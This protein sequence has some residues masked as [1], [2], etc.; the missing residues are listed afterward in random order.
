MSSVTLETL[1][2]AVA[3]STRTCQT[4]R[5]LL[6][7]LAQGWED[8][9]DTVEGLDRDT[10]GL[11]SALQAL[12][13][14]LTKVQELTEWSESSKDKDIWTTVHGTVTDCKTQLRA[15]IKILEEIR[16]SEGTEGWMPSTMRA[17]RLGVS[18]DELINCSAELQ[19]FDVDFQISLALV[20]L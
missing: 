11:R 3:A 8:A 12:S 13:T 20:N 7:E 19:K 1:V 2:E 17:F 4:V 9:D 18:R 5:C 16:G 10:R 6:R 14:T 15:L